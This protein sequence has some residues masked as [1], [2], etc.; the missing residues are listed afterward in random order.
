MP[1]LSSSY[2]RAV[3]PIINVGVY[4][5]GAFDPTRPPPGPLVAY[6]ALLDTGASITCISPAVVQAVG[7]Q[8]IGL[9]SVV[10]A[11]HTVPVNAYLVDLVLPFGAAGLVTP[12]TQVLE[13]A[14]LHGASFQIL[15]GRDIICRGALTLTFDGHFTL[16]L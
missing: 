3:G 12:G 15:I 10:S 13:F 4:P 16:C 2:N 9:R 7:L 11:T 6:P 1:C 8:P 5:S 14:A